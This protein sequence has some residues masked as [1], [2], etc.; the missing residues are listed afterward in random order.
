MLQTVLQQASDCLQEPHKDLLGA[1][2]HSHGSA[3]VTIQRRR[4][5][6]ISH[7]N[8]AENVIASL[9]GHKTTEYRDA[10][11]ITT[12]T[13][14]KQCVK[15]LNWWCNRSPHAR[16]ALF[17]RACEE[18]GLQYTDE[19]DSVC[20]SSDSLLIEIPKN[21][22]DIQISVFAG[23]SVKAKLESES[24]DLGV[25]LKKEDVQEMLSVLRGIS[26]KA[27]NVLR[28]N[29]V[30]DPPKCNN[31]AQWGGARGL[32]I[33]VFPSNGMVNLGN[34][35]RCWLTYEV[36]EDSAVTYV[37]AIRPEIAVSPRLAHH[38]VTGAFNHPYVEIGDLVF[39]CNILVNGQMDAVVEIGTSLSGKSVALFSILRS[40]LENPSPNAQKNLCPLIGR[41][42][43]VESDSL[44]KEGPRAIRFLYHLNQLLRS[45]FPVPKTADCT[46][47]MTKDAKADDPLN[48]LAVKIGTYSKG[49]LV[50]VQAKNMAYNIYI[51]AYEAT[52]EKIELL[53]GFKDS[54]AELSD[55][56]ESCNTALR[57]SLD[58]PVVVHLSC[59]ILLLLNDQNKRMK[60]EH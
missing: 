20:A 38:L 2:A 1:K 60:L 41:F 35:P 42:T 45:C 40:K 28:Q 37:F 29:F 55:L 32:E 46:Q 33:Q 50:G 24:R 34:R 25:A 16:F 57:Q 54:I 3:E 52:V 13:T 4:Q 9:D 58:I 22:P 59:S 8:L 49:L 47:T 23:Q 5:E 17:R 56:V 39:L 7:L 14:V 36:G 18:S 26:T 15:E 6:F 11:W 51:D 10:A 53:H 31:G 27:V 44:E 43:S 30:P 48:L 12:L 21:S 19:E